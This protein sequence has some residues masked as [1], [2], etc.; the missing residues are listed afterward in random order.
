MTR[1]RV[2]VHLA[3]LIT[4]GLLVAA[5]GSSGGST[6]LGLADSGAPIPEETS[7]SFEP[8]PQDNPDEAANEVDGAD[9]VAASAADAA[10]Y[11]L[12]GKCRLRPHA[13][14]PGVNLTG[15]R[16]VGLDLRGADLREANLTRADLRHADLRG[17][18]LTDAKVTDALLA[19][20]ITDETTLCDHSGNGPCSGGPWMA[21]EHV[22][23]V[24]KCTAGLE[25]D[26]RNQYLYGASFGPADFRYA[27]LS[28]TNLAQADLGGADLTGA[29]LVRANLTAANLAGAD[30]SDAELAGV[31]MPRAD[32][33]GAN[34]RNANLNGVIATGALTSSSTTCPD[35]S[36]GPCVTGVFAPAPART[37]NNCRIERGTQ[38][39]GRNLRDA[40]LRG[41]D[42]RGANLENADLRGAHLD[43][44][45]LEGA[46]LNDADLRGTWLPYANLRAA[47]ITLY[48]DG[49]AQ[50]APS[51]L[52]NLEEAQFTGADLTG[53]N[54]TASR[55][56]RTNFTNADLS[57]M[58][59]D[60]R[61]SLGGWIYASS[62]VNANLDDAYL[63][64]LEITRCDFAGASLNRTDVLH[65]ILGAS[66]GI[67]LTNAVNAD[68]IRGALA[69]LKQ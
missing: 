55:A 44:A 60:A 66:Q 20:A 52:H 16:L 31:G 9:G 48:D 46:N 13:E 28:R 43:G 38:C 25:A 34:L 65:A 8:V 45:D 22:Q 41:A 61:A 35:G 18:D 39:R 23:T 59:W 49:D 6:A 29:D 32:L 30:L 3:T 67:D 14:C 69:P 62:F 19:N 2:P 68:T 11:P 33:R 54:L 5:C 64:G 47:N 57:R 51:Y 63:A 24:G 21:G 50:A 36:A 12:I 58:R 27:D 42:L 7:Q 56:K 26:C 1:M 17:A 15:A 40:D 10:Q 4:A 37:I 53:A